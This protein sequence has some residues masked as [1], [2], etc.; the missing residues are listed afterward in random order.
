MLIMLSLTYNN[1]LGVNN[2]SNLSN[3]S[4]L[5]HQKNKLPLM[6]LS[7][8][9]LCVIVAVFSVIVINSADDSMMQDKIDEHKISMQQAAAKVQ[10]DFDT[11]SDFISA[12]AASLSGSESNFD[13][14]IEKKA[15]KLRK[16]EESGGFEH[17]L[18]SDL[19]GNAYDADGTKYFVD[20]DDLFLKS[21]AGNSGISFKTKSDVAESQNHSIVYYLLRL[22]SMSPII[23]IMRS[24]HIPEC[25]F[26]APTAIWS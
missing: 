24:I 23:P 12:T 21:Q 13:K 20:N 10:K 17:L 14:L 5:K 22:C 18:I 4:N 1:I 6:I 3:L 26:S 19:S 8:V 15:K 11:K 2:L 16:L 9:V 7:S 25:I